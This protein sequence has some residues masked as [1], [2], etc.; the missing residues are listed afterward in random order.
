[1]RFHI[2]GR[3]LLKLLFIFVMMAVLMPFFVMRQPDLPPGTHVAS[4]KIPI[5]ATDLQLLIDSTARDP[6]TG[7][8]IIN[9]E[10]FDALLT[11][12]DE[13]DEFIVADFFLWN[14]WRGKSSADHRELANELADAL[15][16]KRR[17][18]PDLPILVITDPINRIYGNKPTGI[19]DRLHQAGIPV[20]FTRLDR[21]PDS[22]RLYS[23]PAR[24]W[25][26][27]LDRSPADG[28]SGP[29]VIPNPFI[30]GG[31]KITTGQL[32]RILYFK[33]NH[34]KV[35]I[36]GDSDKGPSLII[37]SLNPADGSSFHSNIAVRARGPIAWH[38]LASEL[39]IA[40]WSNR[41]DWAHRGE[42]ALVKETIASLH[43]LHRAAQAKLK[44]AVKEDLADAPKVQLLTEGAIRKAIIESLYAAQPTDAVDIAMFY[45]SDRN[46]IQAIKDAARRGVPVRIVLDPN[47]DAF[48]R[49]KNG[50]PNRPVAAEL[51]GHSA[52][53][54]IQIRWAVTDGEQFHSKAMRIVSPSPER[55]ILLIGSANYTR[56]NLADL[57]L[58]A[59][60][61]VQ[62]PQQIGE[63]FD[64]YFDQL[65]NDPS[66]TGNFQTWQ[67]PVL[68]VFRKSILYRIQEWSGASSF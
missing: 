9:H 30:V 15:I 49:T 5:P 67:E 18:N 51:V 56:R 38:A 63:Q 27:L 52:T 2:T 28:A 17:D 7:A 42:S 60:L 36:T 66:L 23:P 13:A 24:F 68:T 6:A 26:M 43:S 48:G 58:E 64:A 14:P 10:I 61:M 29:A 32:S 40:E 31:Q 62:N 25:S 55:S 19:F 54:P 21:L 46:V 45:L 33:A 8:T 20:V 34:R 65:W 11:A 53:V 22:N 57:N 47:R 39:A 50:I 59:N 44:A 37:T 41:P 35:L 4:P 16:E 3:L 12:I 1:M